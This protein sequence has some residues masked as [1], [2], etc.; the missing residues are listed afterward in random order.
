MT[1]KSYH[2]TSILQLKQVL[3]EANTSAFQPTLAIVFCTMAFDLEEIKNCFVERQIALA[4]CSTAGEIIDDSLHENSIALM[5]LDTDPASFQIKLSVYHDKSML[6]AAEEIGIFVGDCFSNPGVLLMSSGISIDAQQLVAG[7]NSSVAQSIPIYGGLAGDDL[8]MIETYAFTEDGVTENGA[9]ILVFDT[10]KI[11]INGLALSGWQPIGGV[12]VITKAAGNQ[13]LEINNEPA[14][15]VFVRYFGLSDAETK[16]DQLIGIQTNYPFQLLRGDGK[17]IL[18]SPLLIHK[19]TKSIILAASVSEGDRFR[20]STSPG[21]EVIDQT[22]EGFQALKTAAPEAD[23]LVLFSCKG[24][25][26]AFGP[27]LKNEIKG[28]Y[29]YWG[30]PLIGF[31]SY[32]EIGNIGDENIEFHN[33]TCVAVT[34]KER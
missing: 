16:H 30:K 20:F 1:S 2:C 34:L 32:G 25:H 8:A 26:G 3:S 31:L 22:V 10:E 6:Q 4:G 13:V 17:S 28:I 27:L 5:L 18:R 33:E 21:F 15:D 23:A 14:L 19:D 29:Q 7:I 11:A 9:A 12:N 24:R